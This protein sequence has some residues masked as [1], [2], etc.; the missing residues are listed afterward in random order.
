VTSVK[1]TDHRKNDSPELEGL[2]KQTSENFSI[3]E[4]SADLGYSSR[5]NLEA[6]EN[7]GGVPY[8]PFKSN[9]RGRAL[10]S[11]I[12]KKM[13]HIF[14]LKQDEF[15]SHYHKRSNVETTF[16]MVKAKFGSRIRNKTYTGMVNELL[17]KVLCHNLCVNIQEMNELGISPDFA[18]VESPVA[19]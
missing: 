2:V 10:G 11:P 16:S 13:W 4:V 12:W 6:V 7:L 5:H 19:V 14:Q 18:C 3:S 1:I 9:S 15:L 8:I 17:C